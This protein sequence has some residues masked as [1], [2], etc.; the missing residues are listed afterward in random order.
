ML[1][2]AATDDAHVN[3]QQDAS[4]EPSSSDNHQRK[5]LNLG[6]LAELAKLATGSQSRKIQEK[7]IKATVVKPVVA[8]NSCSK[9]SHRRPAT[10]QQTGSRDCEEMDDTMSTK[11]NDRCTNQSEVLSCDVDMCVDDELIVSPGSTGRSGNRL[12]LNNITLRVN[13]LHFLPVL[14][15]GPCCVSIVLTQ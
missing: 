3:N 1:G 4:Q 14:L 5:S 2:F 7:E 15:S 6:V 10:R 12:C 11:S 9:S 8:R 13:I